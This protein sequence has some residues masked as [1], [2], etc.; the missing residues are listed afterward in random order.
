VNK[1]VMLRH[2]ATF[3]AFDRVKIMGV[4]EIRQTRTLLMACAHAGLF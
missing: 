1:R 2:G 4:Q 3:T